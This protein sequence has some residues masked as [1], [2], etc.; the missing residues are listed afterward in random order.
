MDTKIIEKKL[1]K[2]NVETPAAFGVMTPQHMVEHL[3]VTIKISYNRIKIPEFELTDKQKFQKSVLLSTD[4]DFPKGVRA[5]G[6][7]EGELMPLR[8][9]TLDEAKAQLLESLTA[10]NSFFDQDPN[11]STVHPGFSKLN[12]A[13]W[14]VFNQK[15]FTHHFSQSGIWE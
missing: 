2:L 11:V 12:L 14:E 6:M 7:S 10:Y 3:T 1:K 9:S 15:H 8:S 13:E 5:P 4:I